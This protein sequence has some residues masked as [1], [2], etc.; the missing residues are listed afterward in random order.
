M[1]KHKNTIK[2]AFLSAYDKYAAGILRHIYLRVNNKEVAEDLTQ[3]TFFKAWDNI[4]KNGTKIRNYKTFLF[5]IANNLIIDHY[6]RKAKPVVSIENINPDESSTAATQ[7]DEAENKINKNLIEEFLLELSDEHR[8]I[9]IFRYINDFSVK[10]ISE[11]TGRS[12]NSINVI[13]HRSI[14]YI[15]GE[16]KKK[17]V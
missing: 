17:Y 16:I 4:L 2:D 3:E 9:I 8:Q 7:F 5:R 10:E 14:K 6:R 1:Q 12:K 13:I 11:L 15:K